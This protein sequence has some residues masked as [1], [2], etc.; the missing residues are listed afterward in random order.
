MLH[1][2]YKRRLYVQ[3]TVSA[4]HFPVDVHHAS[5]TRLRL[6]PSIVIRQSL[7]YIGSLPASIFRL[8]RSTSLEIMCVALHEQSDDQTE[9]AQN[10]SEYLNGE[11]LDESNLVSRAKRDTEGEAY[12][13]GSAASA[14]AALLPLMPTQTPQIRL[15]MPTVNPA[16]NRA[17]PVKMFEGE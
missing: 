6:F 11:N 1:A 13:D 4:H 15:H 14:R 5:T 9:Q 17:Y 10:S 3:C 16:Q 7:E 8:P 2:L 12:S